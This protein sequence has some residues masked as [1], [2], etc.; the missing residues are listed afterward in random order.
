VDRYSGTT[1]SANTNREFVRARQRLPSPARSPECMSRSELADAVNATLY[2]QR[3]FNLDVDTTY[4]GKL[5]SGVYHWI[6]DARR[7]AAFRAV[8]QVERDEDL[9]LYKARKSRVDAK[10]RRDDES[11]TELAATHHA[12]S[13]AAA[14][15]PRSSPASPLRLLDTLNGAALEHGWAAIHPLVTQQLKSLEEERQHG[16]SKPAELAAADARWSEFMSWVCDNGGFQEGQ[17]WLSRAYARS[18]KAEDSVLTAYI[19]MRQ[20]QQA[21]DGGDATTGLR[22]SRKALRTDGL[23]PRTQALCMTRLAE[24]LALTG[25]DESLTLIGTAER[26]ATTGEDQPSDLI[27]RHCDDRYVNAMRARCCYLLGDEDEATNILQDILNDDR[28]AVPLDRGMWMSYL[29]VGYAQTDPER[30]ADAGMGALEAAR[31]AQSARL[32]RALL[33]TAVL[34]RRHRKHETVARFLD[35]HRRTLTSLVPE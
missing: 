23:P 14:L 31:S 35:E 10:A 4:V 20:S 12:P 16:A 19:L 25:D 6:R 28:P 3:V 29:A 24:S 21:L 34:L 5:E 27:S 26:R 15:A 30:A 13:P 32:A 1:V 11:D 22:L 2:R 17:M 7:R 33:P 9:G 18:L 8:L